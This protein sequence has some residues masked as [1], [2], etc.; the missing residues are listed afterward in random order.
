MQV[1]T[2]VGEMIKINNRQQNQISKLE[3]RLEESRRKSEFIS[4]VTRTTEPKQKESKKEKVKTYTLAVYPN[5]DMQSK[6]T[7]IIIQRNIKLDHG[8]KVKDVRKINKGGILIE[9]ER[10]EVIEKIRRKWPTNQKLT[11][12]LLVESRRNDCQP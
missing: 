9:A 1:I 11:K 2:D 3:G 7:K 6:D 12:R 8:I 4:T 10:E 5:E